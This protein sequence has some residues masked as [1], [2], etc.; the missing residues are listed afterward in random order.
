MQEITGRLIYKSLVKSGKS[1]FGEWRI[2]NFVIEKT[3]KGKRYQALFVAKG[4]WANFIDAVPHKERL[5]VNYIIDSKEF[6]PSKWGT[7][8]RV[9]E[10]EKY[11]KKAARPV[12]FNN[13]MVNKD[14]FEIKKDLQLNF[15][16]KKGIDD[17]K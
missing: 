6:A 1:E 10:V 8:L 12:Y 16:E 4:K 17:V 7:D 3:F 11:I 15:N 14:E 5:R 2:I 9:V 13:E